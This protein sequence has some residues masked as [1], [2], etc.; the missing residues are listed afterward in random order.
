MHALSRTH[1]SD[2]KMKTDHDTAAMYGSE[3]DK[4]QLTKN[5]SIILL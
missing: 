3:D 2:N 5:D 1:D 4:D